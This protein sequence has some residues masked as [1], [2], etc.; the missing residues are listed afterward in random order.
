MNSIKKNNYTKSDLIREIKDSG[1]DREKRIEQVLLNLDEQEVLKFFQLVFYIGYLKNSRGSYFKDKDLSKFY[2]DYKSI[3]AFLSDFRN[4][5]DY[6]TT[7][8]KIEKAL[9]V[10]FENEYTELKIDLSVSDS[11]LLKILKKVELPELNHMEGVYYLDSWRMFEKA[12]GKNLP[13]TIKQERESLYQLERM[14]LGEKFF[15]DSLD[16][17]KYS[18]SKVND[19]YAVFAPNY[20]I[21]LKSNKSK[22]EVDEIAIKSLKN[23]S[24]FG[25]SHISGWVTAVDTVLTGKSMEEQDVILEKLNV[26]KMK[27][28]LLTIEN[29]GEII[30]DIKKYRYL[31]NLNELNGK[32]GITTNL[33]N[34]TGNIKVF[35]T[36][37]SSYVSEILNYFVETVATVLDR[38]APEYYQNIEKTDSVGQYVK[39]ELVGNI[40]IK[41][42]GN[43]ETIEFLMEVL[44]NLLR[45]VVAMP[46]NQREIATEA[47]V[48][49]CM[50]K[51]DRSE[52]NVPLKTKKI[53]KF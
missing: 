22:E 33:E 48:N 42:N 39:G 35:E 18:Y 12:I 25:G 29:D 32:P 36:P 7:W 13:S 15:N 51:K 20:N 1:I 26:L 49:E 45:D 24:Q 44:G 38:V 16:T 14:R 47:I 37:G 52:L 10:F 9:L 41:T 19:F 46:S 8:K 2:K 11:R 34:F 27:E 31:A 6:D 23:M 50:M 30:I 40:Y 43:P 21:L 5:E 53:S 28:G 17:D 3:G 4:T